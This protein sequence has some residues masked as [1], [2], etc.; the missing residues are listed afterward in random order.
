MNG[1]RENQELL[2]VGV[3]AVLGYGGIGVLGNIAGVRLLAVEGQNGAADLVCVR[4]N[5]LIQKKFIADHMP[6]AVEIETAGV[7][8]PFGLVIVII[9]LFK[10]GCARRQRPDAGQRYRFCRFYRHSHPDSEGGERHP[11]P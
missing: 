7:A 9:I 11:F 5:R 4:E 1:A 8:T 2:V 10:E 3:F 6:S